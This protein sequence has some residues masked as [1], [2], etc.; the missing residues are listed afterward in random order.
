LVSLSGGRRRRS[1]QFIRS[2]VSCGDRHC[3]EKK[4]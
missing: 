3:I 1:D 2:S 4:S